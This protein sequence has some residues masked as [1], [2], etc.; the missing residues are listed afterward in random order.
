MT[1]EG[2]RELSMTPIILVTCEY[3]ALG[4]CAMSLGATLAVK[5]N[6]LQWAAPAAC[7]NAVVLPRC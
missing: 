7:H 4:W 3:I 5:I 2:A 6:W 1:D